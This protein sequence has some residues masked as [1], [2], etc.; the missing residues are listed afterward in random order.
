ML[1][2]EALVNLKNGHCVVRPEWVKTGEYAC[3][4]PAMGYVWKILT[5]PNPN[6]GNWLP[7]VEDLCADDYEILDVEKLK[8]CAVPPPVAAAA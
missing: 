2:S 4:M 5:Q 1:F 8:P 6:A 3:L 7:T